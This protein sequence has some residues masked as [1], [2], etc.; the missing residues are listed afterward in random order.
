MTEKKI[1]W[2]NV[3]DILVKQDKSEIIKL[4]KELY[5][6]NRANKD[7][8]HTKFQ[9][10]DP[11]EYYKD[12]IE[13]NICPELNRPTRLGEAKKAITQYKKAVGDFL[14]ELELMV[15]YVECGTS[16]IV[17]FGD[18]Y[19]AFYDS[20]ES[21][22]GKITTK[23]QKSDIKIQ[24]LFMPRLKKIIS[25]SQGTGWGYCDALADMFCMAFPDEDI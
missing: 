17:Q 6:L 23:L 14:G 2:K 15:F 4:V 1:N 25:D 18:M 16:E 11:M 13:S 20:L 8:F 19:E 7:Y 24:K 9:L 5:L 21:M 22:F 10:I 12:M 3:K